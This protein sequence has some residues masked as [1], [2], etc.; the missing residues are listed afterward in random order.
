MNVLAELMASVYVLFVFVAR[1][2]GSH[3]HYCLFSFTQLTFYRR[4]LCLSALVNTRINRASLADFPQ[5]TNEIV[6]QTIEMDGFY[7]L[8]K[9]G[10]FTHIVEVQCLAAMGQP[11]G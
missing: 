11:G 5:V 8:D 10:E 4:L 9:P 2:Y 6:R 3:C 7:S 1:F